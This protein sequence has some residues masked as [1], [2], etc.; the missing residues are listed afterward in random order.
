MLEEAWQSGLKS[1]KEKEK[2]RALGL[3]TNLPVEKIEVKWISGFPRVLS[4]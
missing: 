3:K 4:V 1:N 2:I